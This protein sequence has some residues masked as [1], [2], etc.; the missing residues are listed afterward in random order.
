MKTQLLWQL[1]LISLVSCIGTDYLDDPKDSAILTNVTSAS[2]ETGA[3]F[4]IENDEGTRVWKAPP[5]FLK[6]L[7]H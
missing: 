1:L 4:Q 5:K 7:I 3:T 2:L 6:L